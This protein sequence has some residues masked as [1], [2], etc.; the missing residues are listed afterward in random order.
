MDAERSRLVSETRREL[1][2][3]EAPGG[4]VAVLASIQVTTSAERCLKNWLERFVGA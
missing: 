2:D 1:L 4:S 3:A